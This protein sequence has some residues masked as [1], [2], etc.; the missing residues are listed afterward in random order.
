MLNFK[1]K[2]RL[3]SW[4]SVIDQTETET[5]TETE[6]ET[7]ISSES[8]TLVSV[9]R[10]PGTVDSNTTPE[11]SF[12]WNFFSFV[13]FQFFCFDS[14]SVFCFCCCNFFTFINFS[15]RKQKLLS[16]LY[17]MCKKDGSLPLFNNEMHF[18]IV[19]HFTKDV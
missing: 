17:G 11:V 5:E 13:L 16:R 12:R 6:S 14:F 19:C 7:V 4:K 2:L 8:T 15:W 9:L 1:S 10:D 3:K 18:Y